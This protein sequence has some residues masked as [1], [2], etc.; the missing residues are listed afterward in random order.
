MDQFSDVQDL[1]EPMFRAQEP[2]KNSMINSWNVPFTFGSPISS[3]V[4][5]SK[6]ADFGKMKL[7][8]SQDLNQN[9][10]KPPNSPFNL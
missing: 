6:S 3:Q 7:S 10:K 8:D 1:N 2:R 9:T 4:G 5:V